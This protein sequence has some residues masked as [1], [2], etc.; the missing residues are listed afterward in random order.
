MAKEGGKKFNDNGAMLFFHKFII[1]LF[2]LLRKSE[3]QQWRRAARKN[4]LS[5]FFFD[6]K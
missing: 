6:M 3:R 1:P 5:L 4:I 2:T